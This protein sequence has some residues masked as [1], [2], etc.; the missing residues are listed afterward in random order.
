M[1]NLCLVLV[2]FCIS[3][4]SSLGNHLYE[5]EGAGH[6]TLFAFLVY[7]NCLCYVAIP[8]GA[9]GCLQCVTGISKFT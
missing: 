4:L 5:E 6:F 3:A 1:G 7:C 9:N 2:L 8:H